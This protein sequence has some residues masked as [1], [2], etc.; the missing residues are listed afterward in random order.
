VVTHAG[1]ASIGFAGNVRHSRTYG[2][3]GSSLNTISLGPKRSSPR[4]GGGG[5]RVGADRSSP[6]DGRTAVLRS[7]AEFEMISGRRWGRG[8]LADCQISSKT[9]AV[10]SISPATSTSCTPKYTTFWN[11]NALVERLGSRVKACRTL[12]FRFG[13][14]PLVRKFFGRNCQKPFAD[15]MFILLYNICLWGCLQEMPICG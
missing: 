7:C 2:I 9:N 4:I 1:A 14:H 15:L 6:A 12:A 11:P 13:Q 3:R 8:R 5:A 10:R